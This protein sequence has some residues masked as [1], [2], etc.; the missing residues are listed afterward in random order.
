MVRDAT[1]LFQLFIRPRQIGDR[2]PRL[3]LLRRR[4][5][6]P[7]AKYAQQKD[8]SLAVRVAGHDLVR[9]P[10]MIAYEKSVTL[11]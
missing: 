6:E 11:V 7:D 8:E 2:R 9:V 4:V 5:R 1:M 10:S 3:R